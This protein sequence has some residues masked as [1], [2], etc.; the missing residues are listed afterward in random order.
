M[1]TKIRVNTFETNSSSTHSL[2]V[3]N[4][5]DDDYLSPSNKVIVDFID[6]DDE[7]SLDSLKAKVSYLVSHIINRYKYDC[8]N[9]ADLKEQV[10]HDYDFI[11]IKDKVKEKFDKEV[12]LPETYTTYGSDNNLE[13]IVTINHQLYSTSLQELLRD[14]FTFDR[15]LLDETLNP[16]TRIIFGRD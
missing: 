4:Y 14:M 11:C 10:E 2:T 8:M 16:N 3:K 7:Y 6:T 1:K 15:D 9:Y 5:I 13:D 12:M